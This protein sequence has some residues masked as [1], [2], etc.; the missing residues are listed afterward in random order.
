[1]THHT[2]SGGGGVRLHV[3]ENGKADGRPIL[4]IHGTSQCWLSWSKQLNSNLA[5]RYRLV[6]MD[7]RGHGLSDKPRDAYGDSR[8]WADDVNAVIRTLKLDRPVHCG[9]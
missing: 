6:A 8:L 2:I 9:W 3:V 7:M 1:M 4:F 5:D